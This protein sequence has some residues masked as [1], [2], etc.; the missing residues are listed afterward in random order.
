M[1]YSH[2]KLSRL[3]EVP[4]IV[5]F[6]CF[7]SQGSPL[8]LSRSGSREGIGNGSDSDNWRER[9]GTGN[10]LPSHTEFPSAVNSPK[11]KQNKSG[12]L[13]HIS[14]VSTLQGPLCTNNLKHCIGQLCKHQGLYLLSCGFVFVCIFVLITLKRTDCVLCQEK[15]QVHSKVNLF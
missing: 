1:Q 9:N 6:L 7:P 4:L 10:G 14:V 8:S 2:S 11:R 3:S 15:T 12:Q 5:S 13:K